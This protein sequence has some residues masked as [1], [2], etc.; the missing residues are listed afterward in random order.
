MPR[1][2]SCSMTVDAV[3]NRTKKV[4]RRHVDTLH[5]VAGVCNNHPR[6]VPMVLVI[7]EETNET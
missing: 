2:M 4:T 6:P 7:P 5:A 1:R 3:R